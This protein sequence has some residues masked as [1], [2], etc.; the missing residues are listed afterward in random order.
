MKLAAKP[1]ILNQL[2]IALRAFEVH[3]ARRELAEREV[4]LRREL[5]AIERELNGGPSTPAE[6]DAAV[7]LAEGRAFAPAE[8]DR[9]AGLRARR[10]LLRDALEVLE[11]RRGAVDAAVAAEL[12]ESLRPAYKAVVAEQA[13]RVRAV[14]E[15]NDVLREVS[16]SLERAGATGASSVL[17]PMVF[18]PAG[19]WSDAHGSA[20]TFWWEAV[21]HGF[22][23]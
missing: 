22:I 3:P 2:E 17:F 1:E 9:P 18:T 5:D 15:L 8:A 16:E 10:Q 21:E 19:R 4:K 23:E 20:R 11:R 12:L 6:A 13:R 7:A 14:A